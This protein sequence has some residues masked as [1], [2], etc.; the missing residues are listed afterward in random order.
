MDLGIVDSGRFRQLVKRQA[1]R[2]NCVSKLLFQVVI[3]GHHAVPERLKTRSVLKS[4]QLGQAAEELVEVM[5][6][7][8]V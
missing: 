4:Q 2:F 1:G 8:R 7:K 6:S 3:L 5:R